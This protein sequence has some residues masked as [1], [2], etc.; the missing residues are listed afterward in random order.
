MRHALSLALAWAL[1]AAR[2]GADGIPAAAS[3]SEAKA[4]A[5]A[6]GRRIILV[7]LASSLPSGEELYEDLGTDRKL[8]ELGDKLVIARADA[9]DG[10][11]GTT[12]ARRYNIHY[13]PTMLL[14]EA[15][16]AEVERLEDAPAAKELRRILDDLLAG[17]G[18]LAR[19]KA[20]EKADDPESVLAV[21]RALMS[22][23]DLSGAKTRLTAVA[24]GDPDHRSPQTA[25]RALHVLGLLAL[26]GD[27][28]ATARQAFE[29]VEKSYAG[30]AAAADS[31][32]ALAQL[33][34][35]DGHPKEALLALER[36]R[37][38]HPDHPQDA[39]VK[40]LIEK[41]RAAP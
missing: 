12:L 28:L 11:E 18:P 30:S 1:L 10:D 37:V 34:A 25:G 32:L 39:F 35:I 2:A 33:D 38:A 5:G 29:A 26:H 21:G 17:K 27:D 31:E 13:L 3:F 24:S 22:R 40:E 9:Y 23:G 6:E 41:L 7:L 14:L 16:G 15:D 8:G 36:F 19:M 20:A 4:R